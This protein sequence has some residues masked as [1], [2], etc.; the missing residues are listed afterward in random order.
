MVRRILIALSKPIRGL[1]EAAYLIAVFSVLA[2][3]LALV[4]DRAFTHYFGAGETLDAY[5]AAFRI[6]DL[7]FAF[8]TLFVSS[9][10]L[11]PLLSNREE[12]DQGTLIGNVLIAFGVISI[13]VTLCLYFLMPNIVAT[14]FPG[15]SQSAINDT[16]LMSRIMLLQPLLLGLSSIAASVVQVMRRFVI[17]ALA[18][19]FYNLGIIFGVIFLYPTYGAK[20]LAW[21][22]V[23]GALLH[24]SAE[25]IPIIRRGWHF[26]APTLQSLKTSIVEVAY[27]SV[28]RALALSSHNVLLLAFVSI[29]TLASTGAVSALSL[30][31]NLQSVPLT[32]VGVSYAAALFPSLS[33]LY[34]MSDIEAFS[35]EVWATLR[36][37]IFWTLPA[38]ALVI[39][40]RA[41]LVRVAFGSGEFSWSDTRLTAAIL[42]LFVISLVAQSAL[43]IFSR[44]YYAAKETF[45]PVVVNVG[46]AI[47]AAA[48]AYI[49]FVYIGQ[50]PVAK[51][52]LEDLFR[53]NDTPG[54]EVLAIPLA[55]SVSLLI[56]A[57]VM[58]YMFKKKYGFDRGV[59][60]AI[61]VSFSASVIG[62][63]FAYAAL[64]LLAPQLP[65]ETFLGIFAQG[66]LAGLVGVAVTALTLY[67]LKSRELDEV[68]DVIR[69][70]R[71]A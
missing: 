51:Y 57:C 59:F 13:S 36:H 12:K 54:T 44:A 35:K 67:V 64:Q 20:G 61:G 38:I 63:S 50:V 43:L 10:A 45:T 22:V 19:I 3:C 30:A 49:G 5:F 52:F 40:L 37:I 6:P 26:K 71:A 4:R 46:S 27:P 69:G 24:L 31:L 2:Q 33:K 7:V 47:F 17:Y 14:L 21:G 56:A 55:Y 66:F 25:F 68:I 28:P 9:F 32:I 18:P 11:V 58:G 15:F 16:L 62:A 8:L 41:Q 29:A 53:V 23:L 39:V 65:T 60:G 70:R 42:A 48:S 34:A 1:H